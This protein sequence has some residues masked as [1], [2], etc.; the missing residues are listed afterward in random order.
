MSRETYGFLHRRCSAKCQ[1]WYGDHGVADGLRHPDRAFSALALADS[2]LCPPRHRCAAVVRAAGHG[3]RRR[4]APRSSRLVAIECIDSCHW[5]NSWVRRP[6]GPSVAARESVHV[7]F[8]ACTT[9]SSSQEK[10]ASIGDES[11]SRSVPRRH[12]SATSSARSRSPRVGEVPVEGCVAD[13]GPPRY[14]GAKAPG[15]TPKAGPAGPRPRRRAARTPGRSP[16]A[17]ARALR[18]HRSAGARRPAG[19]DRRGRT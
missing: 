6:T 10:S 3:P 16:R 11:P 9:K 15:F 1:E 12:S 18:S 17:G 5:S 8:E 2:P 19:R 7:S 13:A 14:L 4:P